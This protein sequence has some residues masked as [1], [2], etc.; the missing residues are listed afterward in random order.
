MEYI[1][2][3]NGA[4]TRIDPQV[5]NAM[6]PY[7]EEIYGVASS[8]FSHQPGIKARDALEEARNTI[9]SGIG[10]KP[11]ELIFTSGGTESN[12]FALKGMAL[13]TN[14]GHLIVSKV[15]HRSVLYSARTLESMG[16][17]VD[18]LDVDS[19]GQ[20]DLNKLKDLVTKNTLLVSIQHSNHEIGT[21][22]PIEEIVEIARER[23]A[24]VHTDAAYSFGWLPID[25]ERLG[26][27]LLTITGHKI[28]GPKGI[29]GL[30]VRKGTPIKKWID[31]GFNEFDKRGGT[32]NIP[33]A[34]GMARAFELMTDTEIERVRSLRDYLKKK[35][36]S[37]PN[38]HLNGHPEKR[39][40]ANLNVT[41]DYIEGESVVLHLDMRNI[42][43]ITGSACFSRSLEP[44]HI[45]MATGVSHEHAHGS[46]RFS[47]GRFNKREELDYVYE[48]LKKV[49][50]NLRKLSPINKEE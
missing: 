37:I 30:Y 34:V 24:F 3:D 8:Q 33:G 10:A 17:K 40:P 18:Y 49:I 2:L 39:H 50:E 41:F 32:E 38:S 22:Q 20:I 36:L 29:G 11:E 16:F 12:N 23:G 7:F 28:H 25:V 4:S 9:A 45:L 26:V 15:E 31:G 14:R 1:Y 42:G 13:T 19:Y 35:V 43:V 47:L 27:D 5:L 21:L 44:S 46:I 48:E 6:I